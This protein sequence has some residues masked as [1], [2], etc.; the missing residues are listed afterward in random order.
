[1]H[2]LV[3]KSSRQ[4]TYQ[5]LTCFQGE[6]LYEL[7]KLPGKYMFSDSSIDNIMIKSPSHNEASSE[8]QN[9]FFILKSVLNMTKSQPAV[10]KPTRKGLSK[11]D[12]GT[13]SS[14]VMNIDS[15]S[16]IFTKRKA[17][18]RG[19]PKVEVI[20]VSDDEEYAE[21]DGAEEQLP[22]NILFVD[23]PLKKEGS[24]ERRGTT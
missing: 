4:Y 11:K 16:V 19:E 23:L 10:R 15:K 9:T 3:S 17:N 7:P 22:N 18:D 12:A 13:K 21:N 8:R 20:P 24:E 14:T 1:M 2:Q 6:V 5:I